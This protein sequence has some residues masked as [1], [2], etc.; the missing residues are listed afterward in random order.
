MKLDW[1]LRPDDTTA[2][3]KRGREINRQ[4]SCSHYDR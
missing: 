1:G 4:D 3:G 2:K